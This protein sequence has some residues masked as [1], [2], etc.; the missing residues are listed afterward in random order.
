M[1]SQDVLPSLAFFNS[2]SPRICTG[3]FAAQTRQV[4]NDVKD[5]GR[6][7]ATVVQS[8]RDQAKVLQRCCGLLQ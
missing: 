6:G 5:L 8:G 3:R 7:A 1:L 2:V 4:G